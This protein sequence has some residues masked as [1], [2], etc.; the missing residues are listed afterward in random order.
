MIKT[1]VLQ[2]LERNK[3]NEISGA[4]LARSLGVSRTAVWKAIN[5]LCDSGYDIQK[6]QSKGYILSSK[7][8]KLSSEGIAL[9]LNHDISINIFDTLDS[10]NAKALSMAAEGA[11]HG[12]LIVAEQQTAGKGRLGRSFYSPKDTGIYLSVILRPNTDMEKSL[13][14][15]AAAA[16]AVVKSIEDICGISTDIKWVNDIYLND[17]KIC[18]IL[19]EA[20]TDF[21]SGRISH[22]VV[23]IG[24]NCSTSDFDSELAK[25]AGSLELKY[26]Q[27]NRLTA[28]VADNLLDI[29]EKL[30]YGDTSFMQTYKDHSLVIGKRIT[31]HP[32]PIADMSNCLEANV[33]DIDRHGGLVVR[34]DD[35][36]V[37]TLSSGE[38]SVRLK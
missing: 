23:G 15:T 33:V 16:V 38:I 25:K 26:P 7:S 4:Q 27:R 14:I 29:T 19:T 11:S 10:T 3:G 28:A 1:K 35:G 5:S 18:G 6:I 13:L 8:D 20:M 21:E 12:T 17:K 9:N 37:Q 31:V 34:Y 24:I 2:E 36:N 32:T 30:T 22:V